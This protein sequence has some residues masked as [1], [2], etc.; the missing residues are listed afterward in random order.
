[1]S[2]V[3]PRRNRTPRFEA[4]EGRLTLSTAPALGIL[5]H[6]THA[7]VMSPAQRRV[8][9]SF[10]GQVSQTASAFTIKHLR[11]S[12]GTNRFVGSASGTLSAG[13]VQGGDVYLSNS[14]GTVHLTLGPASLTQVG[15]RLRQS[16]PVVA[17]NSTGRYAQFVGDTGTLTSWS[18]PGKRNANISFGGTFN[19]T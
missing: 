9:V 15:K 10:T 14:F 2:R 19:L 8:P 3:H 1:M 6:Q 13:I 12:I 16:V 11:G 4:L 7:L 17:V 18:A 5:S